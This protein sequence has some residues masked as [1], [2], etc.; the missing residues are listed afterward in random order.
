MKDAGCLD[1]LFDRHSLLS[2]SLLWPAFASLSRFS[3]IDND[4]DKA[5]GGLT[6]RVAL[7]TN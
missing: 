4:K 1:L 2:N 7:G 5:L 3:F 6:F